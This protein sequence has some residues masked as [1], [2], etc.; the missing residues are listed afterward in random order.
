V[1]KKPSIYDQ[2]LEQHDLDSWKVLIADD[3]QI[4]HD[5][6]TLAL[7]RFIFHNK[8]ISFYHAY[9]GIEAGEML[10]Q[11]PDTAVILMDVVME[12]D[13]AGLQAARYIREELNN[14]FVRIIIRTGL[15]DA[16]P[17][18]NVIRDYD[19]NDYKSKNELTIQKLKTSMYT[20]LRMY[21]DL[22]NLDKQREVLRRV[23]DSAANFFEHTHLDEFISDIKQQ[24][25]KVLCIDKGHLMEGR[26]HSFLLAG[27]MEG[28]SDCLPQILSGNG[29][30]V[31]MTGQRIDAALGQDDLAIIKNA[32]N[33]KQTIIEND[34][35]VFL[36]INK[37]GCYGLIYFVET[38]H[39][40]SSHMDLM[41][42][43]SR[44]ISIACNSLCFQSA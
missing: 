44:N 43:F 32:I 20:S 12:S 23:I 42:L 9:S 28:Q 13:D 29:R 24:I 37:H 41:Q 5:V 4:I 38:K 11:N 10:R 22:I 40:S 15:P 1:E 39:F 6:T 2:T 35:A 26:K 3:D 16:A 21:R 36:S 8:P 34:K 17:E 33:K 31:D 18:E 25:G 14:P 30:F 27:C 7:K 19:I